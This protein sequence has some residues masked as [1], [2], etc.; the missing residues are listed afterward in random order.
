MLW[1]A[2]VAAQGLPAAIGLL[3]TYYNVGQVLGA[4]TAIP[5]L[6]EHT[7]IPFATLG[8]VYMAIACSFLLDRAARVQGRAHGKAS[9]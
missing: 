3:R 6:R 5:L 1:Y 7:A 8:V 4:F 2:S 9:A